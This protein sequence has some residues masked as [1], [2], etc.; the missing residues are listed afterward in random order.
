M[1]VKEAARAP[2][3]STQARASTSRQPLKAAWASGKSQ[4]LPIAACR[5]RNNRGLVAV[6]VAAGID[7]HTPVD[8]DLVDIGAVAERDQPASWIEQRLQM[9]M[10]QV[11][12]GE[13][14]GCA[15]R[16]RP[17]VRPLDDARPRSP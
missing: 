11:D 10:G 1:T 17:E 7:Q 12:D 15:R 13:I 4:I 3:L 2:R 16:D 9:G 6:N 5:R 14:G 8:D